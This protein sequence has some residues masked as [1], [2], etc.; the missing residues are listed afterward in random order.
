MTDDES[1]QF[2]LLEEALESYALSQ[3]YKMRVN[4]IT[5]R[6]NKFS[7]G[8]SLAEQKEFRAILNMIDNSNSDMNKAIFLHLMKLGE[9]SNQ[10]A[11]TR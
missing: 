7:N 6:T 11:S 3:E 5:E 1:K 4:A 9:I 8:L 2:D 10:K